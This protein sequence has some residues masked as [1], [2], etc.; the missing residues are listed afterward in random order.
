MVAIKYYLTFQRLTDR[1]W[2]E[3]EIEPGTD[4][5]RLVKSLSKKYGDRFKKCALKS[6]GKELREDIRVT[7]NGD[8]ASGDQTLTGEEEI[9]FLL[10]AAGG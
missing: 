8:V 1:K 4:L 2:E 7:V 3:V 10:P 5:L 9:S 6:S